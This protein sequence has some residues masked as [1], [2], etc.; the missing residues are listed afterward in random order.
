M[1]QYLPVC[2]IVTTHGVRGEMKAQLL[3]D[4]TAFL[5]GFKTLYLTEAGEGALP[6]A[7]VRAQGP[8]ALI[9]LGGIGDMDAARA[10]MGK[11]LYAARAEIR[12]PQGRYLV[13]DLLGCA[14]RDA[15][16]GAEYGTVTEVTHPGAQDLYTVTA[17]D[18]S[19]YLMPAVKAFIQK[20]DVENRVVLVTPI[21]GLFGDA[22]NGDEDGNAR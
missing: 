18:G 13:A 9:T 7:G 16:T 5:A 1:Q 22:V 6:L 8:M 14:V 11:T 10:M 4:D 20:I 19:A 17:P 21:P 12:L 15:D 2:K 3:C